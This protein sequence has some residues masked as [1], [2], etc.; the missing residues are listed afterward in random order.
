MCELLK[1]NWR[2]QTL[3]SGETKICSSSGSPLSKHPHN[4]LSCCW[5]SLPIWINVLKHIDASLS[6]SKTVCQILNPRGPLHRL[7]FR[8]LS[9]SKI[10]CFWISVIRSRMKS[11]LWDLATQNTFSIVCTNLLACLNILGLGPNNVSAE[12]CKSRWCKL[13]DD[14]N[15]FETVHLNFF[16]FNKIFLSHI[17]S[18]LSYHNSDS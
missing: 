14:C 16:A 2:N 8:F 11:W 13:R 1:I 12:Q 6:D 17:Q 10:I 9:P 4:S 3:N 5:C 15:S 18:A 7:R